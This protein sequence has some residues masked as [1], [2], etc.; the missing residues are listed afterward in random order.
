MERFLASNGVGQTE[1]AIG[2][3]TTDRTL[4]SFRKTEKVRRDI[5]DRIAKQMRLTKEQLLKPEG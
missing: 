5:F 4:R 3:E 1:F 2:A